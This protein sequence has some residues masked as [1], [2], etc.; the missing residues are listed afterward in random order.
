[1]EN[2]FTI[3]SYESKDLFCDREE[4]L[5]M[6]FLNCVNRT[7]MTL[8]S[9]RRIGKTG[10]I[11]RLFDE[12][13][14]K[15][16]DI[17]PLYFDIFASRNIDDFIKMMAE[18]AMKSF[19]TK[20]TLGEK[21]L[22]FI[23]SLRP[24]LTFDNI[25]GEP[26]L[27]IAYQS[28]HE[29]EYTL[30]GLFDFLDSQGEHIVIAIDEFQQIRD[31]PEQNM[32]ALLRT[33]IQRTHNLTFIFCGSKKHMM[34]D[35][36]ANEKKP[37]YNSTS[38]VSLG[39]ISETS[40]SAFIRRLFSERQRSITD[41]AL[42]FILNWTG[43]HT[44]YTQQLCHTVYANG[45]LDITLEEVK[46]ACEQLMKQGET[47]YLQYR[48]MLTDK[49]WNY[50]IAVAKEGSVRQITSA[51]FLK[52]HKIGT[53]SVSRRLADALCEKGLLHEDTTLEGIT[54]SLN[55]VFLSRWMERL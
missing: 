10:L 26:Q 18:A 15:R 3:K 24:Q 53:P 5:Q 38:F 36:F 20:T 30:R 54:Y 47:V 8:I 49:Q 25:T 39:K 21:L 32:E 48:Q 22:T 51:A 23:K 46:R 16:P 45:S 34:A 55:D 41:E 29:K 17:V 42:Q 37:F 4:E 9:Q 52:N 40:Y 28:T 19:Q 1:M 27:Q 31:Y 6:M 50:L 35:I 7:D 2:P 12:L 11:L 14:D 44:Y 13:K 43:R 33:Y